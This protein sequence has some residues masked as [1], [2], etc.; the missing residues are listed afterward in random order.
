MEDEMVE[1][2]QRARSLAVSLA[3]EVDRKNELL[4]ELECKYDEASETLGRMIAEKDRMEQAYVEEMRKFQFM[5]LQNEKLK[6]EMECQMRKMHSS[7][8][9][10]EKL[11]ED[12][13]Y[14]Q[15]ELEQQAKILKEQEAQND[16]DRKNFLIE[17]EKLK[18]QNPFESDYSLIV[19]IDELKKELDEKV[20]ELHDMEIL[21]QTLILRERVC[22][23]EIQ[24]AR[25]ELIN[26][27]P[28]LLEKAS[29]GVK[30]MGEVDQKPFQTACFQQFPRQEWE[31]RSVELSSLWQEKLKNGNWYPFKKVIKDGEL[32]IKMGSWVN[33]RRKLV[34]GLAKEIDYKNGRLWAVENK[35]DQ[36]DKQLQDFIQGTQEM[37]SIK[38]EK[39][40]L[41]S[42]MESIKEENENLKSEMESLKKDFEKEME[43]N[44]YIYE[45]ERKKFVEEKEKLMF[46]IES[47]KL[48]GMKKLNQEYIHNLERTT[49]MAE[50][51]KMKYKIESQKRELERKAKELK[52]SGYIN[53]LERQKLLAEN[54]NMRYEIVSQ[55]ME[56]KELKEHGY[57]NELEQ[58]ILVEEKEKLKNEIESFEQRI[59]DLEHEYL[60]NLEVNEL[61]KES[62]EKVINGYTHEQE[63]KKL[64]AEEEEEKDGNEIQRKEFHWQEKGVEEN[65]MEESNLMADKDKTELIEKLKVEENENQCLNNDIQVLMLKE[66]ISND[67]LQEARKEAIKGL[68]DT[69]SNRTLFV[70]KRMGEIDIKPFQ[71]MCKQK[72]SSGEWEEQCVKLCSAW[73]ENVKDPQWQPFKKATVNGR[74]QKQ[75][76]GLIEEQPFSVMTFRQRPDNRRDVF[77]QTNSLPSAVCLL[78]AS[79]ILCNLSGLSNEKLE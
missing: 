39:E 8:L 53:D 17:M 70:I 22:N 55:R 7:E 18:A 65:E 12:L 74:L 6:N 77:P 75:Q 67:E 31:L 32:Q 64:M 24:D 78:N 4:W 76:N 30:R 27:L 33:S 47:Q 54:E 41:K 72:Y 57:I 14:Q 63:E 37:E 34:I 42:E 38:E 28:N 26:V 68:S 13:F 2:L 25:K 45:L 10:N 19:Q 23:D 43:E 60:N 56:L 51:E 71:E 3:R 20:D 40:N 48:H 21:N 46:Q 29:V 52:D 73:A 1:E 35:L 44:Q 79:Y 9:E 36:K 62:Q 11:K 58:K 5:G 16:I 15:K 50:N 59:K 66:R 61:M 69:L 49:L